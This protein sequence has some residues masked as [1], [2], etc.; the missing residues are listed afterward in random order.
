ME[1]GNELILPLVDKENIC[2]PLPI[3]VVSTYWNVS[4]PMKEA[5]KTARKYQGFE[6]SV[7]I[8]GIE[9]AERYGS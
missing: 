9:L 3:N 5:A 7:L 1:D 2:L 8:E 4:L 6:G